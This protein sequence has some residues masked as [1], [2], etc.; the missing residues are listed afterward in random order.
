VLVLSLGSAGMRERDG[1][2][3]SK[4]SVHVIEGSMKRRADLACESTNR[5]QCRPNE[6]RVIQA[7][8]MVDIFCVTNHPR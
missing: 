3:Y 2:G 1:V 6:C 5:E 4:Q 8:V 7:A